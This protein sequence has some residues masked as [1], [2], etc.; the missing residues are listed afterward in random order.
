MRSSPWSGF[1]AI[2]CLLLAPPRLSLTGPPPVW[3]PPPPVDLSAALG[4]AGEG[5][6]ALPRLRSFLVS[7][8]GEI[9]L[10][11]YFNGARASHPANIKSASKSVMSAL[12]GIAIDRGLIPRLDTPISKYF[13]QYL[14]KD[15]PKASITIEDLVSMRSGLES[16]SSRNYGAWVSSRSWVRYALAQ[17]LIEQ[18][19]GRM[20]Y[21]TGNTHLLSAILTKAAGES[22]LAFAQEALARPLGFKLA[23]WPRD[24]EGIYFGGNDMEMTPR[25]M[26]AFGELYRNGGRA[27]GEQV[28]PRAWIE[29]TFIPRGRSSYSGREYG[30]GWWMRELGGRQAYYAWGYGGQFIF[31]VPDLELVVVTTSLSTGGEGRRGHLGDVYDV[32]GRLVQSLSP[33]ADGAELLKKEGPQARSLP[34]SPTLRD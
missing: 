9:V 21:S 4:E 26:W 17:E 5:A 16:T 29:K 34:R 32:V 25:Q 13:P 11:R 3:I 8:N 12:V 10:E 19:G 33:L 24:P 22:T 20:I 18:P 27:G 14:E 1:A 23:S 6:E 2:A 30:Y 31:L 15:D 28:L 7:L